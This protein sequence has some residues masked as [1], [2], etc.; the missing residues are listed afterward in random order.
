M[1]S[2]RVKANVFT[3]TAV[4]NCC[5]TFCDAKAAGE[6]FAALRE[7]GKVDASLIPNEKTYTALIGVYGACSRPRAAQHVFDD[8]K[9]SKIQP[10]AVAYCALISALMSQGPMREGEITHLLDE[11]LRNGVARTS[12]KL[13]RRVWHAQAMARDVKG[14]DDTLA[15]YL[16]CNTNLPPALLLALKDA[17]STAGSAVRVGQVEDLM[18]RREE[19]FAARRTKQRPMPLGKASAPHIVKEVD[20]LEVP[21]TVKVD[22]ATEHLK[23]LHRSVHVRGIDMRMAEAGLYSVLNDCGVVINIV[24][25]SEPN[26]TVGKC[27]VEFHT[28]AEAQQL[29]NR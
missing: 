24:L 10:G 8:M 19:W 23:R 20:S 2:Q 9:R 13:W 18:K 12:M 3:F 21:G 26:A 5:R 17:Y 1:E 16:K 22:D 7:A 15:K 27:F 4:I 29:L 25:H 11:A 28:A 14:I 6:I